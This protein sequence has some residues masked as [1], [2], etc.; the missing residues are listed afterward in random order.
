V[1]I[2]E[3]GYCDGPPVQL[4]VTNQ[5][6]CSAPP[7]CGCSATSNG[8][9]TVYQDYTCIDDVAAFTASQ[10]GSAPYLVVEHYVEGTRCSTQ[11]GAVVFRADGECYYNAAGGTSFRI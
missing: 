10:F 6:A 9:T 11:Q 7:K 3:D 5:W 1:M 8:S 2:Y 4:V